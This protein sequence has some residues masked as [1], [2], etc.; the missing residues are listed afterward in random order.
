M[1]DLRFLVTGASGFL[2]ARLCDRLL[3]YGAEVHATSRFDRTGHH[4]RCRWWQTDLLEYEAVHSLFDEIQP[5]VVFHLA[6]HVTAAPDLRLVLPVFQSLLASTLNV[7]VAATASHCRRIVTTGSLTE[8]MA[9]AGEPIPSSP[10]SAAKWS[11][12]A[13]ARMFQ[14]LYQTP[15]VVLRP[16]MTY[17]PGQ[18]ASKIV[19]YV[20][21]SLIQGRAPTLSSGVW[22]ADW[23]FVDDVIDAF[24][25]SATRPGI[26]G[27]V[28][29]LGCGKLTSIRDVVSRIAKMLDSP[30]EPQFGALPDRPCQQTRVADTDHARATLGWSASTSLEQGLAATVR[31]RQAQ[32]SSAIS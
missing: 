16:F 8:P 5:D 2:G 21:D 3:D 22:S 25:L 15:I 14:L 24:V 9:G 17:G 26:D 12:T 20:I 27:A 1:Q 4:C 10:Y 30:I 7:L 18:H 6:G 11:A 29:D 32:L 19:P 13:Y 23:V 31:S 28:I